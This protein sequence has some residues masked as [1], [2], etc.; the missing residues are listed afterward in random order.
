[1]CIS[2]RGHAR[3]GVSEPEADCIETPPICATKQAL[4]TPGKEGEEAFGFPVRPEG[5][6]RHPPPPHS[7][8][9]PPAASSNTLHSYK[10]YIYLLYLTKN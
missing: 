1:M 5:G 7:P 4:L 9:T 6:N 2:L 3:D 8:T 10:F